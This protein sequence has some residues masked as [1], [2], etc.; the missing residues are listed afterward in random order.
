MNRAIFLDRD[1]IINEHD[2]QKDYYIVSWDKFK[3]IPGTKEA[4]AKLSRTDYLIFIITNQ[5]A[6]G[7]GLMSIED[8]NKIHEN[9]LN[10]IRSVGGRIDRIY[11]CPHLENQCNC[12]KPSPMLIDIAVKEFNLNLG[13]SWVIGDSEMDII[14]GRARGCRTILIGKNNFCQADYSARDLNE[15]VSGIILR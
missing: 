6:I 2:P 3:F 4:I 10:E 9:M 13:E 7:K 14:M 15:A 1:G 11:Y 5:Q 12:R 8:L